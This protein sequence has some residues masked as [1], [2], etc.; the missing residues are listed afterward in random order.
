MAKICDSCEK[1]YCRLMEPLTKLYEECI[2]IPDQFEQLRADTNQ[3]FK[4]LDISFFKQGRNSVHVGL[5]P[6][7]Q[8]AFVLDQYNSSSADGDGIGKEP[9][10]ELGKDLGDICADEEDFLE[11]LGNRGTENDPDQKDPLRSGGFIA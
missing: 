11:F 9:G 1:S 2:S 3:I 10:K 5:R 7:D 8:I 4:Q 6:S